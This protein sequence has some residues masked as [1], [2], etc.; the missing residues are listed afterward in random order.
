MVTPRAG[1]AAVLLSSGM[2]LIA[3]GE[4]LNAILQYAEIFDPAS[5]TLS[6]TGSMQVPRIRHSLTAFGTMGPALA[7]GGMSA[8]AGLPLQSTEVY[9]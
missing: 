2:V 1:H 3:G 6:N 7:I 4:Y 9:Q 8:V 5:G